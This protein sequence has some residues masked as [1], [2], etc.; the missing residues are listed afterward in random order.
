MAYWVNFAD[1]LRD[2]K[3]VI[4]VFPFK[5]D[6]GGFVGNWQIEMV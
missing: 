1:E 4:F 6:E 3:W 2:Y 5:F